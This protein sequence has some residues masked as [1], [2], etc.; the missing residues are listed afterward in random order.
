MLVYVAVDEFGEDRVLDAIRTKLGKSIS[1]LGTDNNNWIDNGN[2]EKSIR[3]AVG[4][5]AKKTLNGWF[6][7]INSGER[8]GRIVVSALDD[9]NGTSLHKSVSQIESWIYG[10]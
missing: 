1:A 4:I 9:I 3:T 10:Y 5:A 6:K 8:L 7:N 2:S